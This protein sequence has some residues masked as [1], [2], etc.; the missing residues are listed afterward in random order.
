MKG[1]GSHRSAYLVHVCVHVLGGGDVGRL[2]ADEEER[3][4]LE[5]LGQQRRDVLAVGVR[6]HVLGHVLL[7]DGATQLL[8]EL[9]Q[10]LVL[11]GGV[12]ELEAKKKRS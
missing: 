10:G 6:L 5:V 12:L 8:L 7:V 3:V 9:L 1:H 11:V 4:A 2:G